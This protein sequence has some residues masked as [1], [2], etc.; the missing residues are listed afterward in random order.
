MFGIHPEDAALTQSKEADE[1]CKEYK[2]VFGEAAPGFNYEDFPGTREL[3]PS[4]EWME[5]IKKC[6]KNKIPW[7]VDESIYDNDLW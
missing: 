5:T 4:E 6:I 1:L 3:T 2:K 7:E